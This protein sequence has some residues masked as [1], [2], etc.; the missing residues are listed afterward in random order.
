VNHQTRGLLVY[1]LFLI[2]AGNSIVGW[3]KGGVDLTLVTTTCLG[4]MGL[5]LGVKP[6]DKGDDDKDA[7]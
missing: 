5:L 6:W 4:L 1:G 2:V 7:K 3:V